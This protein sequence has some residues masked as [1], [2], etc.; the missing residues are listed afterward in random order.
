M[1]LEDWD[2]GGETVLD[3]S[4]EE[5]DRLRAA[6]EAEQ[7][8]KAE[9]RAHERQEW[10]RAIAQAREA[11]TA[12]AAEEL[13]ADVAWAR[14]VIV[15]GETFRDGLALYCVLHEARKRSV[16]HSLGYTDIARLRRLVAAL[17]DEYVQLQQR[18][19]VSA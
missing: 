19:Q 1:R 3:L 5:A 7:T 18:Q 12:A 9:R 13:A 4:P 2:I 17:T 11:Q 14:T 15:E 16:G 10:S 8:A 6:Y